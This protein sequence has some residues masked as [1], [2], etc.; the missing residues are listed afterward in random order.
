MM[1]HLYRVKLPYSSVGVD[2][3]REFKVGDEITLDRAST[4]R[5][6]EL[7][8]TGEPE[9]VQDLGA[10][11][12]DLEQR[13][14]SALTAGLELQELH[15]ELTRTAAKERADGDALRDQLEESAAALQSAQVE[16]AQAAAERDELRGKLQT[17]E[18]ALNAANQAAAASTKGKG[19]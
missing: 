16:A 6:L 12:T 18:A 7:I 1:K 17:A 10:Q 2:G 3:M 11:I 14:E 15:A 13:L 4:S 5:H 19:K 9:P 8:S